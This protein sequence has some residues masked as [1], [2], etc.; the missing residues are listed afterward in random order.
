ML[1]FKLGFTVDDRVRHQI[2]FSQIHLLSIFLPQGSVK[3]LQ[4]LFLEVPYGLV[5]RIRGF[6]PRGPGSIPGMGNCFQLLSFIFSFT[7]SFV[8]NSF[9]KIGMNIL[10]IKFR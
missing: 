6:H 4:D 8:S 9:E 5:V 10:R 7:R 2:Y 1:K 3:L